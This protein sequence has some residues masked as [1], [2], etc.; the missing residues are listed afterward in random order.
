[1]SRLTLGTPEAQNFLRQQM[2]Q[3]FF[4]EGAALPPEYVPPRH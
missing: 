1:E 4:G 3:Y 2:E